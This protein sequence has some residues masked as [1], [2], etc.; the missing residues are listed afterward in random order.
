M[1]LGF[2][3]TDDTYLV[4]SISIVFTTNTKYLLPEFLL[5]FYCRS[6]FDRY[7]RFN[8]WGSARETFDWKTMCEICIPIPDLAQ[9]EAIAKIYKAY[10]LRKEI[11]EQLKQQIKDICPVLIKGS[12]EEARA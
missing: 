3:D 10:T 2:N 8:S 7:A 9:Q 12:L 11:C 5:L 1:S 4:S 6:E